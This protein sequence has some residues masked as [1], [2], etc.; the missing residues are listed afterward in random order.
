MRALALLV[1]TLS[2]A[3]SV[4]A[5]PPQAAEAR[6]CDLGGTPTTTAYL[7]N[8]TKSL[9]GA[10][11]W[12]TP[13]IVQNV[14]FVSTTLEV[15]FYRFSDGALVT[16]RKI[17]GLDPGR[18]FADVPNNDTDLPGNSQF[19]VVVRSYG[20]EIV[21]VVN[22]QAGSG[23]RAEGLSYSGITAGS[24]SVAL[25]YVAKSAGGWLTTVIIQNLGSATTTATV[26]LASSADG[27]SVRLTRSIAPGR[28]QFIDPSVEAGIAAGT[29][30]SATISASQPVA[31]VVNAHN[32]SA[33][34]A[35]P[36]GFSYNGVPAGAPYGYVPLAARNGDGART[37][38]LLVQNTG[39]FA[40]TP[41]LR[42]RRMGDGA[43][44]TVSATGAVQPGR[45]WSLDLATRADVPEGEHGVVVESG[46]FA[47]LN[48]LT[49]AATAMG[50]MGTSPASSRIYLPNLTRR[51][52]GANG[53]TTPLVIQTGL[54]G[55][56]SSASVRW[57]RFKDGRLVTQQIVDGLVPGASRKI[58]PR[59]V[60][61]LSDETQYAVVV[62]SRGPITALVTQLNDLG[63][64]GAMTYEGF[65]SLVE[66]I[67]VPAVLGVTPTTSTLAL[68]TA[69]QLSVTVKDQFGSAAD[70]ATYP[71]SWAV[72]P[73]ELGT[74]SSSGT[75]TARG[76]GSGKITA[77]AGAAS[78]SVTVTVQ[79][80][81]ARPNAVP[82]GYSFQTVDTPRGQ[83]GVHVMKYALSEVTIRTVTGNASDCE[84]DCPT[85]P[86]V[87]YLNETGSFAGMNGSY[88]CPPDYAQ[89]AGKVGS[90]DYAVYSGT[91][92]AWLNEWAL[93]SPENA[94]VTISGGTLRF[95]RHVYSYDRSRVDGAISN[96]P[97]LLLGGAVV[98]TEAEQAAYQKLK[99]T[100]GSIGTDGTYVYLAHVTNASMTDAA[101]AL[102]AL[103][104]VDAMNLDGGGSSAQFTDGEYK[105]GPGRLLPN[106]VVLIRR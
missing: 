87:E 35:Q 70:L 27:G 10:T 29:E 17:S 60:P 68:G 46:T 85:Q 94:L 43:T 99:G 73:P 9:G 66:A 41:T 84:S 62:D 89:C 28:S 82:T 74:I 14:G 23:Q 31:A 95:Y 56:A 12:V 67:S 11:G 49:S 8:V 102:Q 106:A 19:S 103:G 97:I 40:A 25:P 59:S 18:S 76:Y 33:S 22:Q 61:E 64:D 75:F 26:D 91:L 93:V 50:Y 6:S 81:L 32:D 98:D 39:T 20:S 79:S 36:R 30:Y 3:V 55:G 4:A 92:G 37:S 51:L 13:F 90:Y 42:F 47:V 65:S 80:P 71:V 44:T 7:P 2:V 54:G 100:K 24:R 88:F 38:R 48:I 77:T 16:C 1:A 101:Y 96:F 69:T 53:W 104:V 72:S 58:D 86:L 105:V 45:T 52:G 63:G 21:A 83:F 34:V 5:A 57:Y 78:T 15:S